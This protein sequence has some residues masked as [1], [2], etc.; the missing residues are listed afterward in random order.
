MQLSTRQWLTVALAFTV[1]VPVRHAM[2]ATG[3]IFSDTGPDAAAYGAAQGYPAQRGGALLPQHFMVGD[4]SRYDTLYS[5]HLVAKPAVPSPLRRAAQEITLSYPYQGANHT[6]DEYLQRNPAT[7]LLIARDDTILFEHYQ[8]GRTDR[9]R[10]LSQSMAKTVTSMLLG[11]A[12]SEGAIRSIDQLAADYV[13]ELAGSEYGSTSIRALLHMASGVAFTEV[14]DGADDN[15]KLGRMRFGATNP[16]AARALAQFNT[17]EVAPG[18]RFHYASS[19]TQVLGLVIANA[20]HMPL[21]AYLQSRIWQPMGAEADATWVVDTGGTEVASCC[22]NATLR[23][24]ARFAL[25]LANDG[26]WNGRQII[27]RQWVQ[28]ATKVEALYLAPGVATR[29]YGYG[30]QVWLRAGGRRQFALLGV[31]GQV[32]LIDPMAHLVLVHTA[33]RLKASN[34]PTAAELYAL[35]QALVVRYGS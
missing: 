16:G 18:T 34:D 35:W 8:Y 26:A 20:V 13:P 24:W 25:L 19:E 5:F 28:D 27:P 22:L 9:D 14:Y 2:P 17:R 10:L 31:H 29:T 3:P 4:Y 7:G 23:D 12:V 15:A 11:I 1:L 30:Y 21:A 33:V 32:I 6:L